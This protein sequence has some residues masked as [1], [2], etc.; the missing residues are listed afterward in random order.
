MMRDEPMNNEED[1]EGDD[2]CL[3]TLADQDDDRLVEE[4]AIDLV[5][6]SP[7]EQNSEPLFVGVEG[8]NKREFAAHSGSGIAVPSAHDHPIRAIGG[9]AYFDETDRRPMQN[10]VHLQLQLLRVQLPEPFTE[11]PCVAGPDFGDPA[12]NRSHVAA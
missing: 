5:Q 7:H 2:E 9:L 4:L 3:G 6:R 11:T 10:S 12:F 1:E 8:V